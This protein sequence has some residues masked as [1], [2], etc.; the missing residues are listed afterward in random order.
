MNKFFKDYL[1][2]SLVFLFD[3]NNVLLYVLDHHNMNK[4]DLLDIV[5][6]LLPIRDLNDKFHQSTLDLGFVK[7]SGIGN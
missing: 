5:I 6:S 3:V 2:D 1:L 7:R 4:V